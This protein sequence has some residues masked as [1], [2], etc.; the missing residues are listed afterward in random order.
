MGS[1]DMKEVDLNDLAVQAMIE[2]GFAPNFPQA[3]LNQLTDITEPAKPTSKFSYK[4][5]RDKLWVSIDNDD[6]RDLDQLT[7]SEKTENGGVKIYIAVAD[8]DALVH[9]DSAIDRHAAFNTTSVYTPTKVFPML[10][11]KLSTNLTSLNEKTDRCA[12]VIEII[13]TPS[14]QYDQYEIYPAWV[15]NQ[16]K[17]TYNGVAGWLENKSPLPQQEHNVPSILDQLSL[18][19]NAAQLIQT[20]RREQG[21]LNFDTAEIKAVIVDGQPARLEAKVQNR[22]NSLIENFMIAGN[23]AVTR[24]LQAH[25]LPTISRVV[26]VP[27]KWDEI[28]KLAAENGEKL[29]ADPDPKALRDFLN[30]RRLTDP[31]TFPDLSLAIIKLIGRGEY[32]VGFPEDPSPGHFDLA[33]REYAHTTAPNRR[34]PDVIM[35][36]L[37]KSHFFS[38]I[39]PYQN[40]ELLALAKHCT[41]KEDDSNKVERRIA[42]SAAAIVLKPHIGKTFE[43]MITGASSKGTWVRLMDPPIEG[44]VIQNFHK[45]KVG[46]H[47]KVRLIDVDIPMGFIDFA[48]V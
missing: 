13:V 48:R 29:P 11:E 47:V 41:E 26:R 7:Y 31:S 4:D 19:D 44:K 42:K 2:K 32:V 34:Y 8:V 40:S 35:Q 45:L 39:K 25:R 18:Q 37:L 21:A 17:L 15:H 28:I 38:N 1:Q 6:S 27:Q 36:R 5:L 14:G 46:D 24:F 43:G 9:K 20:Y 23:V 30:K 12:M 16:A 3:V 22:A 10:P 33:L